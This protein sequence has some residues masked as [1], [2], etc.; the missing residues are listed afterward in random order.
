MDGGWQEG[1]SYPQLPIT[2]KAGEN[3]IDFEA[4]NPDPPT[5]GGL[6]VSV[7]TDDGT[8]VSRTG[9]SSWRLTSID[10]P[11]TSFKDFTTPDYG[12]AVFDTE[13]SGSNP[14]PGTP[15]SSNESTLFGMDMKLA[16]AIIVC[17]VLLFLGSSM[18]S[19]MMMMS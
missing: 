2:L 6:L 5:P 16:I 9:D 1:T 4:T 14:I 7:I 17:L 12:G 13:P 3:V 10:G 15:V 18:M 8:V 19:A 11:I